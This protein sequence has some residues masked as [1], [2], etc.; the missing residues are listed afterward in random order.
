MLSLAEIDLLSRGGSIAL[1]LLWSILLLRYNRTALVARAAIAMNITIIAYVLSWRLWLV[2]PF[3]I[4]TLLVDGLSV[5]APALFWLFAQIWFTDARQIGWRR[6]ALVGGFA[7]LPITQ[8][9]LIIGM[10]HFSTI[11]WLAVRIGM[12]AFGLAGMWTAWRGRDNDLVEPRRRFRKGVIWAIGAFVIWVSAIEVPVFGGRWTIDIKAITEIAIVAVTFVVSIGLYG[13]VHP[14][15]FAEPAK[16]PACAPPSPSPGT[17]PLAT[18][19]G[20]H[21]AHQ[22]PYRAEGLTI[23]ALAAQLGEQEYR[24]RRLINGELGFR[25]FTAF[26]NNYRLDEVRGALADPAQREVPIL[27]IALD[28]GFGSLGPFNRAF[29]EAEGMTP[30]AWRARALAN[31]EID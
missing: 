1:L 31:S 5:M 25:N 27:T 24:L 3:S 18:Q 7:V 30:S 17:S 11:C 22:R 4:A 15:L 10:G 20:A 12:F 21:M 13:F 19:L 6:W 23:A 9:A 14:Q 26:L 16:G 8:I 2:A 29:R 28:A